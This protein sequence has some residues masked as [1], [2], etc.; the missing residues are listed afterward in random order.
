M[1]RVLFSL[2]ALSLMTVVAGCCHTHG[3]C[4][5]DI[6]DHCFT[7]QPW[8]RHGGVAQPIA[9]EAAAAPVRERMPAGEAAPARLP[10][11]TRAIPELPVA[12]KE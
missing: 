8:L 1:R 12:G 10:E 7:R 5:C 3:V 4:D 11:K 6:D 2:L 9:G